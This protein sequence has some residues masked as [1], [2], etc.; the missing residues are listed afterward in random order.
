MALIEP[1]YNDNIKFKFCD[2][3]PKTG[4]ASESIKKLINK[5]TKAIVVVH[6]G[7]LQLISKL[8]KNYQQQKIK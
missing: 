5:N 7:G 8:K 6:W 1:L 4:N 2:I 3:D